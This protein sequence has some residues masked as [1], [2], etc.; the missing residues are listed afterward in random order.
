MF[1]NRKIRKDRFGVPC[2]IR[3]DTV[4][5]GKWE[6]I[7]EGDKHKVSRN[8]HDGQNVVYS[9]MDNALRLAQTDRE[10]RFK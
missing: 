10:K 4:S 5:T 2:L 3:R 9:D 1:G 7:P 6:D 8:Y